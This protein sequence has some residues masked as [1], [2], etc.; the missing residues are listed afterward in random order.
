M[1]TQKP[2]VDPFAATVPPSAERPA[3]KKREPRP[4]EPPKS[5]RNALLVVLGIVLVGGGVTAGILAAQRANRSHTAGTGSAAAPASVVGAPVTAGGSAVGS[6]ASAAPVAPVAPI[7]SGSGSAGSAA[8]ATGPTSLDALLA[9]QDKAINDGTSAPF[10]PL[11]APDIFGF[12]IDAGEVR[13]GRDG[14]YELVRHVIGMK[15]MTMTAKRYTG[16][17]DHAAWVAEVMTFSDGHVVEL[18]ELA[19]EHGGTWRIDAWH[20]SLPL[21]NT[22]AAQ[23]AGAD[24]LAKPGDLPAVDVGSDGDP[25]GEI[26]GA[27]IPAFSDRQVYVHALSPKPDAFAFGSA[28]GELMIGGAK[29]TGV[30]SKM[31]ASFALGSGPIVKQVAPGIAYAA[32]NVDFTNKAGTQT[33]RVLLVLQKADFWR[34]VQGHWSNGGPF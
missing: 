14:N 19:S 31:D 13:V 29:V 11:L 20:W 21:S 6:A 28:P 16:L 32:A 33:F 4:P 9:A 22:K 12:G 17:A 3:V 23:L 7:A 34:I 10:E 26:S 5:S 25:D 18:S 27:V 15:P 2:P 30:F 8:A 1:S 24:K